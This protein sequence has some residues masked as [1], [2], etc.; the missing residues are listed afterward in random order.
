MSTKT[1]P[2]VAAVEADLVNYLNIILMV[3]SVAI[4]AYLPFE[5]FLIAYAVLGPLHYLTEISWLHDRGYFTTGS[6]DWIWLIGATLI[7]ALGFFIPSAAL[8]ALTTFSI[9]FTF[10]ISAG[11]VFTRSIRGRTL[12]A[13]GGAVAGGLTL[14]WGP[15][16]ALFAILLPTLIHVYIFTGIFILYGALKGRSFS[17]VLSLLIFI[18]APIVCLYG[19][20]TPSSYEPSPYMLNASSPFEGL[21]ALMIPL[22]GFSEDRSGVLAFMRLMGFAYSYH[23]LNWFSKTRIINWHR[24]SRTRITAIGVLYVASV[25][26]YAVNYQLGFIVLLTLSLGHVLLEFPL[27]FK[28][29]ASLV[30]AGVSSVTKKA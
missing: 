7:T 21:R 3:I 27:N 11:M 22:F 8:A 6:R 18:A 2:S 25:A 15:F 23:Y 13:L 19:I 26:L 16:L 4:A 12:F 1:G 14:A 29:I 17:G 9:A 5:T 30:S 24:V 28:T 20:D 10:I